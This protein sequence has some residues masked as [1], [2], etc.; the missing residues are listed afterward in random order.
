[1]AGGRHRPRRP[2]AAAMRRALLNSREARR[3]D[4][5]M[6]TAAAL[7]ATPIG[8]GHP[9]AGPAVGTRSAVFE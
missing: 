1:M 6:A 9:F 2:G 4:G 5:K 7:M 8:V 3:L